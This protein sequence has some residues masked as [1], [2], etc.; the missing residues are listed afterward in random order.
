MDGWWMEDR[1]RTDRDA[2]VSATMGAAAPDAEADVEIRR[3]FVASFAQF[4]A[5][6]TSA[7]GAE[8]L[9]SAALAVLVELTGARSAM[10]LVRENDATVRRAT[11]GEA[12]H[13]P[14][15]MTLEALVEVD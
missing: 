7:A 12:L 2:Q 11:L 13:L 3:R 1:S 10:A 14:N 4:S 9:L 8:E 6:A 5:T 15:G